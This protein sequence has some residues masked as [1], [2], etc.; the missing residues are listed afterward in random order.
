MSGMIASPARQ[1]DFAT[2]LNGEQHD[3]AT[4][5]QWLL[6]ARARTLTLTDDVEGAREFDA[7][8]AVAQ[9]ADSPMLYVNAHEAEAYCRWARRRLP[10]EAEWA[11]AVAR[12]G[13]AD[14]AVRMP[15]VSDPPEAACWQWTTDAFAPFPGFTPGPYAEYSAPWFGDHRVLRGHRDQTCL[16]IRRPGYRNFYRPERRDVRAGLRT[17]ASEAAA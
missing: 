10:S 9:R 17:C 7:W 3:A 12:A 2:L 1:F 13:H 16:R 15:G 8:I 11:F 5:R 6:D 4:L 14:P